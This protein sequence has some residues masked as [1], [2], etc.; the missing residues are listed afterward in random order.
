[1]SMFRKS[2]G[3]AGG[4]R[5]LC[6]CLASALLLAA[7]LLTGCSR[8][9]KRLG[10]T[11]AGTGTI[12]VYHENAEGNRLK[13][14]L[15][16]PKSE[17]F[18]GI[19]KEVLADFVSPGKREGVSPLGGDVKINSTMIG[20]SEIDVDFNSDYLALDQVE[21]LL[22]RSALVK[23]LVQL[24]GVDTVRFTVEGQP[25][26]VG[27]KEV[28]PMTDD[29]F[30]IPNRDAINSYR[31]MEIPLY[32]ATAEG[33]RLAL[34]KRKIYYSSNI[35]RERI[36]AEQIISG[37]QNKGLM[38]VTTSSTI[39]LGARVK[40]STCLIDFSG[41]VNDLPAADSS[42]QPETALYA[43][44][45]AIVQACGEDGITA[46]RFTIEGRSD[47]RFRGQVNLDQTFTPDQD[48]VDQAGQG[49]E[50]AGVLV[51]AQSTDKGKESEAV[52]EEVAS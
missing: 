16:K 49:S 31:T 12:R 25:L 39:V 13:P 48:L 46:V 20:I 45:N 11:G 14:S 38:P 6:V 47:Q 4:Q 44:V 22:L 10:W 3:Q 21:E 52:T 51:D 18:E 19:L 41:S 30:I 15:L 27:G 33:N 2:I 24:P 29:S 1:M 5:R 35:N 36:V 17:D 7:S 23:T 50:E 40:G 9:G 42:L 32:F 28:G 37:P 34:E 8:A 43:F 26:T